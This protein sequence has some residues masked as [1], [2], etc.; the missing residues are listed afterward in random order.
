MYGDDSNPSRTGT[1]I[2]EHAGRGMDSMY[3]VPSRQR[4]VASSAVEVEFGYPEIPG[5]S[6]KLK[7]SANRRGSFLPDW[8]HFS[9]D[10]PETVMA[11]V[12]GRS[13]WILFPSQDQNLFVWLLRRDRSNSHRD[14]PWNTSCFWRAEPSFNAFY[15]LRL[16]WNLKHKTIRVLVDIE[17]QKVRTELEDE[18]DLGDTP[19]ASHPGTSLLDQS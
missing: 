17:I 3:S 2:L 16:Y 14:R 5:A 10:R 4:P 19:R 11:R 15:V 9:C 12:G 13:R 8:S 18:A 7:E 6:A 1:G